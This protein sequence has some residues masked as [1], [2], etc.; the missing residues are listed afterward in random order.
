MSERWS[1][2]G[3]PRNGT[4]VRP[5]G[6][7]PGPP[8]TALPRVAAPPG[9]W[10]TPA[11]PDPHLMLEV[12]G[13]EVRLSNPDKVFFPEIGVTKRDLAEYYLAVADAT[14]VHLRERPTVMK[15]FVNGAAGEPFFQKRVP[16]G[17]PEWLQ[18]AT[19]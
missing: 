7:T 19:V 5:P 15:R 17:A 4:L 14:L 10:D 12:A 9:R 8:R 1:P 13:H 16:K 2:R 6:A 3:P 18:T 11:V